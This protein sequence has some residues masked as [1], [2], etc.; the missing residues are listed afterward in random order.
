VQFLVDYFHAER[1]RMD[2]DNIVKAVLH[3][4]NG[5]AYRD[6][7]QVHVVRA[8][9]HFTGDTFVLPE[10]PADLV[11]SLATPST[12][13]FAP[14]RRTDLLPDILA[15]RAPVCRPRPRARTQRS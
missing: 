15:P 14:A 4:L 2:M 9:A 11:K 1:R 5:I 6:D 13:S 12:C 3:A 8:Q 10:G 7:R